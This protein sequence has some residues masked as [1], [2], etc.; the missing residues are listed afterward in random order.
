MQ[1]LVRSDFFPQIPNKSRILCA[2]AGQTNAN[3]LKNNKQ[4]AKAL[5]TGNWQPESEK[6]KAAAQK[7]VA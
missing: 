4:N 7:C 5:A 6:R 3:K 1:K 2:L